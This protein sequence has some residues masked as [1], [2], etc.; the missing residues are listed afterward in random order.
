MKIEIITDDP[1]KE[2]KIAKFAYSLGLTVKIDGMIYMETK[3]TPKEREVYKELKYEK[4]DD[5]WIRFR[6]GNATFTMHIDSNHPVSG[7]DDGSATFDPREIIEMDE[8]N[9]IMYVEDGNE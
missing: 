2:A 8:E 6:A 5:E 9:Q 3:K 4:V 7:D 1:A